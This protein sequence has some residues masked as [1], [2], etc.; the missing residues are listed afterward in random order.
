M[1]DQEAVLSQ[2]PPPPSLPPSP[3]LKVTSCPTTAGGPVNPQSVNTTP[4]FVAEIQAVINCI[5]QGDL[6]NTDT[7]IVL[8]KLGKAAANAIAKTTATRSVNQDLVEATKQREKR[9]QQNREDETD[10]TYTRVID[11]KE[12][13][14]RK[15][16]GIQKR[17]EEVLTEFSHASF[18]L[19]FTVNITKQD[20]A[21]PAIQHL[22][23]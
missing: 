1:L 18:S 14:R 5:Q 9:K 13:Q 20:K 21:P 22:Q 8:E 3:P 4:G 11:T 7:L 15:E 19:V 6:S 17:W 2:L 23:F 10:G 16:Y 12:L